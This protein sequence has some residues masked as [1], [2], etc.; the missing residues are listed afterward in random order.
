[1]PTSRMGVM[2]QK[3]KYWNRALHQGIAYFMQPYLVQVG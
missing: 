1:M 3:K 2:A